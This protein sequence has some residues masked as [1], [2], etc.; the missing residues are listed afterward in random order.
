MSTMAWRIKKDVI[1]FFVLSKLK[2]TKRSISAC[3]NFGFAL[4][5]TCSMY[6][7]MCAYMYVFYVFLFVNKK[8]RHINNTG[9]GLDR[10]A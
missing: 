10:K 4:S 6:V 1:V 5:R 8:R 2:C 9:R 7:C 3:N